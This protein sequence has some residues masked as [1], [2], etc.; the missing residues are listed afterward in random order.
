MSSLA[1]KVAALSSIIS[2]LRWNKKKLRKIA[3]FLSARA[4]I[5]EVGGYFL[6][7]R[8]SR[9]HFQAIYSTGKRLFFKL[10]S[11]F[12]L[13][14][15]VR[16]HSGAQYPVAVRLHQEM[17]GKTLA[18]PSEHDFRLSILLEKT[19]SCS[20]TKTRDYFFF[21]G[22]GGSSLVLGR[23]FSAYPIARGSR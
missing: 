21:L 12:R 2:G 6:H 3:F 22:G 8:H 10:S 1:Q 14:G 4:T 17:Q 9:L 15:G 11:T 20:R 13:P 16:S 19:G 5:N 7:C 23:I 18:G